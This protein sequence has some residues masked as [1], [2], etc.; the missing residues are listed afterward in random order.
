V[1]NEAEGEDGGTVCVP[2]CS[3]GREYDTAEEK[4]VLT[5]EVFY[6]SI[7]AGAVGG[8]ILLLLVLL[9]AAC[10]CFRLKKRRD[11]KGVFF[12]STTF[13]TTG[14]ELRSLRDQ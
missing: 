6:L 7:A 8:T 4:C 9:A 14:Q 3:H 10:C 11:Q 12:V 1:D 5:R 2:S 13:D